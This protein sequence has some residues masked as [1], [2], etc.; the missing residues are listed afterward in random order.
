MLNKKLIKMLKCNVCLTFM[1]QMVA[2]L[3]PCRGTE[4][5]R[6]TFGRLSIDLFY[7]VGGDVFTS[8]KVLCT[9]HTTITAVNPIYSVLSLSFYA[10]F[11][12]MIGAFLIE[13]NHSDI[14]KS[15]LLFCVK[16][17]KTKHANGC[18]IGH[19]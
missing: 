5:F 8:P 7:I 19:L 12:V 6:K 10:H 2:S 13:L 4:S 18:L 17:C 1:M 16:I 3:F 15:V 9:N 14:F 11:W